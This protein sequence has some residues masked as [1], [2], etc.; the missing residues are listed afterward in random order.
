MIIFLS[1]R[2]I[3][4]KTYGKQFSYNKNSKTIIENQID[5]QKH[6]FSTIFYLIGIKRALW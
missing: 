1:P 3:F 2:S 6:L 5:P 4:A